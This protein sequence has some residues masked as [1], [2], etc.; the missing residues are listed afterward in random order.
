MFGF[1]VLCTAVLTLVTPLAAKA[2]LGYFI[3]LRVVEGIG[4]VYK[5]LYTFRAFHSNR[6]QDELPI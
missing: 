2:G 1:G 3:A 6:A 4:E 5:L